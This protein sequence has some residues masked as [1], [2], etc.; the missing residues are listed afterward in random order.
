MRASPCPTHDSEQM[1]PLETLNAIL[2]NHGSD[3][4]SKDEEAKADSTA[5]NYQC[6]VCFGDYSLSRICCLDCGHFLC[7]EV[8]QISS[9]SC[10]SRRLPLLHTCS[11]LSSGPATRRRRIQPKCMK[12]Y[13]E[14]QIKSGNC[15]KVKCPNVDPKCDRVLEYNEVRRVFFYC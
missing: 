8:G 11:G 13:C 9:R 5:E 4:S 1:L 3:S 7:L 6:P 2:L 12:S 15:M 10:R 14:S